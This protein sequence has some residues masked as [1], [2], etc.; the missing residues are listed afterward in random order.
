[1]RPVARAEPTTD[2]AIKRVVTCIAKRNAA[3]VCT[4]A[5]LD[6]PFAGFI[7]SAVFVGR[8]GRAV[9]IRVACDLVNKVG[10][11]DAARVFDLYGLRSVLRKWYLRER[12][13]IR[14]LL[15]DSLAF[16]LRSFMGIF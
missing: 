3:K 10:H 5:H 2:T 4:H 12:Q 1:M 7:Q 8:C 15:L 9:A 14:V 11:V 16:P 6:Q 13:K